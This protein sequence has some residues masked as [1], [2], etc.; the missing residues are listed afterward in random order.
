[1]TK[2]VLRL[3]VSIGLLAAIAWKIRDSL[4]EVLAAA[5]AVTPL[6]VVVGSALFAALIFVKALRWRRLIQQLGGEL[7]PKGSYLSYLGGIAVGAVTPGRLGEFARVY[8]ARTQA[9]MPL[10]AGFVSVFADRAYD[11]FVLVA[12]GVSGA[13]LLAFPDLRHWLL[14]VCGVLLAV[15]LAST[16]A[17]GFLLAG[18]AQRVTWGRLSSVLSSLARVLTLLRPTHV[19]PWGYTLLAYG[20]YFHASYWV[21]RTAG[22][23]VGLL[24]TCAVVSCAGLVVLL[25][26]SIAGLGT[27]ELVFVTMFSKLG[28]DEGLAL[29]ASLL[30]FGL[31]FVVGSALGALAL[32]A[33]PSDFGARPSEQD[34]RGA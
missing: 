21:V 14:P 31:F 29:A 12:C 25:P 18:V 8:S 27:R 26:V 16:Y 2:L 3:C 9:G 11:L 20:I 23:D 19:A 5:R 10:G 30:H 7:S 24:P 32:L 1:M 6:R 15:G 17:G 4:G 33:L 34:D 22:V 28:V 13:A